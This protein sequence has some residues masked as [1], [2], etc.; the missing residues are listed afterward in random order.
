MNGIVADGAK[1]LQKAIEAEVRREH[2]Q[3]RVKPSNFWTRTLLERQIRREVARRMKS[4]SS[5]GSLY[6]AR[7]F[8]FFDQD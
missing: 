7:R 4:V 1:R 5:P 6:I 8:R 2:P 3:A